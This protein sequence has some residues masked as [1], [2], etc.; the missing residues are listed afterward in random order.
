MRNDKVCKMLVMG[1]VA[2]LALNVLLVLVSSA[3]H[4]EQDSARARDDGLVACRD[5]NENSGGV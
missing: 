5:F 2:M 4:S 1:L 3:G